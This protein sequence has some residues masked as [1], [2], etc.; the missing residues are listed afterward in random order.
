MFLEIVQRAKAKYSFRIIDMCVMDNHV[1]YD[2]FKSKVVSSLRHSPVGV[3]AV[4]AFPNP[5]ALQSQQ[6]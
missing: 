1:W 3:P 2:R 4:A 6:G 5:A